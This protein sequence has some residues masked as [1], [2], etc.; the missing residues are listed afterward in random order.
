LLDS[1]S[2]D[3]IVKITIA[4]NKK[5][6]STE[7]SEQSKEGKD[8]PEF[9]SHIF[10]SQEGFQEKIKQIFGDKVQFGFDFNDLLKQF[11]FEDLSK[12]FNFEDLS[13]QFNFEDFMKQFS[14]EKGEEKKEERKGKHCFAKRFFESE[15]KI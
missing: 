3:K 2:E 14:G 11:N 1:S 12:Q 13:K 6:K 15:E 4:S 10:G 9:L 5:E 7:T 8:V